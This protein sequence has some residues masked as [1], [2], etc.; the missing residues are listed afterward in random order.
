MDTTTHSPRQ[1]IRT[2]RIAGA[3]ASGTAVAL[4]GTAVLAPAAAQAAGVA[5]GRRIPAPPAAALADPA[6]IP[7]ATGGVVAYRFRGG[8]P[9]RV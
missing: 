2:R 9:E 6:A 5:T 7:S 4:L 3:V 1:T 8:Q